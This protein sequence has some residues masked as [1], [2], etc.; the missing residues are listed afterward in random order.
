MIESKPQLGCVTLTHQIHQLLLCVVEFTLPTLL[1]SCSTIIFF[2]N[3]DNL[4]NY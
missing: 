2:D 1:S 4:K 3:F